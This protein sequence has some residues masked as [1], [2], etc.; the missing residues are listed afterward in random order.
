[1]KE[2]DIRS[3]EGL[4]T[5]TDCC[6]S[7]PTLCQLLGMN[8]RVTYRVRTCI[9]CYINYVIILHHLADLFELYAQ[10]EVELGHLF[11]CS[12]HSKEGT[13]LSVEYY[14]KKKV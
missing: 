14:M 2:V 9:V 4:K 3:K 8:E 13:V 5:Q 6:N 11:H 1:M 7:T 10:V 12:W